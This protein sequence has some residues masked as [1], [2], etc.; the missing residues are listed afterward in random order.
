MRIVCAWCQVLLGYSC[1]LCQEPL[2]E[3]TDYPGMLICQTAHQTPI[4]YDQDALNEAPASH[5]ICV[6]CQLRMLQIAQD[7]SERRLRDET[8]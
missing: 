7:E 2:T 6:A 8:C 5:G 1:E 4:L 3:S